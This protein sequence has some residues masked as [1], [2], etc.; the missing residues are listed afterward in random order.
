MCK[1]DTD[2]QA[3]AAP[4]S[5]RNPGE[6]PPTDNQNTGVMRPVQIP[7]PHPDETPGANPD[8]QS[9]TP[10]PPASPR[11]PAF[12]A[13]QPHKHARSAVLAAGQRAIS[14]GKAPSPPA[15]S[16]QPQPAPANTPPARGS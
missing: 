3:P 8:E 4:P 16:T 6:K 7:K 15:G 11:S 12:A 9:T 1:P 2:K 10:P 14:A 5:L 13:A